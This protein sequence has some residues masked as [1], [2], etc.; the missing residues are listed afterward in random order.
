MGIM[1][2]IVEMAERGPKKSVLVARVDQET[3]EKAAANSARL[4]A[5]VEEFEAEVE[6]L[7]EDRNMKVELEREYHESLWERIYERHG[8]SEDDTLCLDTST[9][10]VFMELFPGDPGYEDAEDQSHLK[11][12]GGRC[13]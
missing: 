12:C 8:L 4:R 1:D 7:I 11:G 5:L 13:S 9:R 6:R 3:A 2:R 10:R